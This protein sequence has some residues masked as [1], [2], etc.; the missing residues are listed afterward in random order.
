MIE[1]EG[2][3]SNKDAHCWIFVAA[4]SRKILIGLSNRIVLIPR[5]R[6]PAK[7]PAFFW[8]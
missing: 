8:S 2:S 7:R 4:S 6:S 5:E 1:S 3:A